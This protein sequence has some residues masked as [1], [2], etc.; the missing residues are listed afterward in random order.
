MSTSGLSVLVPPASK[1]APAVFTLSFVRILT[2]S[3]GRSFRARL[4]VRYSTSTSGSSVGGSTFWF[5]FSVL[6]CLTL[7]L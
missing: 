6:W 7:Y 4:L 2:A 5:G 3:R 1:L